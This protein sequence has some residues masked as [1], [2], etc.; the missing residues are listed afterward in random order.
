MLADEGN[1]PWMQSFETSNR[2]VACPALHVFRQ[3]SAGL[4][5]TPTLIRTTGVILTGASRLRSGFTRLPNRVQGVCKHLVPP[6]GS[7]G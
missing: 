5:Q 1:G 3:D 6:G 7:R 4:T 2:T